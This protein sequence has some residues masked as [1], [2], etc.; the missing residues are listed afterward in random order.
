[1]LDLSMYVL[2]CLIIHELYSTT[3]TRLNDYIESPL[4]TQLESDSVELSGL[5]GLELRHLIMSSSIT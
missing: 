3:T 4:Q 5:L 1:M 2:I